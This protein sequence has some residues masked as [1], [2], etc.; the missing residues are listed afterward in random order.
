MPVAVKEDQLSPSSKWTFDHVGLRVTDFAL[1][2]EWYQTRLGF[3]LLSE[4]QI[5]AL[6]IGLLARDG[7]DLRLE[8]LAEPAVQKR[9]FDVQT[10]FTIAGYH[11]ICF[12]SEN[13]DKDISELE[14]YGVEV[15]LQP[16]DNEKIGIR[17]AL[18]A[19]PWGNVLELL[20]PIN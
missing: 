20:Q 13:V 6:T 10:S 1:A 14:R 12:K 18:F 16:R 11:H 15:V 3:M 4:N 2:V 5:G 7:D 19:D 17:F 9:P 8:L